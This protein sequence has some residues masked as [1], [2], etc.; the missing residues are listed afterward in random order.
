MEGAMVDKWRADL[1]S[2]S[3]ARYMCIRL[4]PF[5]KFTRDGCGGTSQ[6][7]APIRIGAVGKFNPP[8]AYALLHR[9]F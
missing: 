8:S 6:I 9:A 3:T 5:G 2:L 7:I 1:Q 4:C